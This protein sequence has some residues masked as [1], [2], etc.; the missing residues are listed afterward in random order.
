M[1]DLHI[2]SRLSIG[3]YTSI[4]L[5]DKIKEKNLEVFS[6]TDNEHCL[7]YSDFDMSDY[8]NLVTGSIFTTSIDGL[9]IN[10]IGYEV[11]PIIVNDFYF[12][13]YGKVNIEKQE[14]KFFDKLV[15]IMKDNKIK[16]S[17]NLQLSLVEKGVSKKLVYYDALKNNPDFEFSSYTE[18]YRNG[19]SNP[20]SPFFLDEADI[21]PSLDEIL[22]LIKKAGGLAFLA[23]PYEYAVKVDNLIKKLVDRGIDGLEV[24]HPSAA[25][26]QSLKLIDLCSEYNLHASGGSD[27]RKNRYNIPIGVNVHPKLFKRSCFKWLNKYKVNN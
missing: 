19:L 10:I 13:K 20:F 17:D 12:E 8:P 24:F 25:L 2:H 27:F 4:Q 16:L 14:Y 5:L 7:A 3:E 21:H 15:Q 6:I 22:A 9:I 26:R 1:I 11:N 23:H 18:F